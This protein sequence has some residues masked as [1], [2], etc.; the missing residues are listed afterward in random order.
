MRRQP[1][2]FALV[3]AAFLAD[4]K[5]RKLRLRLPDPQAFNSAV[6]AWLVI[7]TAAR[8]NGLP[9]LDCAEEAED[10]TYL[11]DLGASNQTYTSERNSACR[12][13]S[14]RSCDTRRPTNYIYGNSV[15]TKAAKFQEDIDFL[16]GL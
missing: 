5:W 10:T 7:L 9:D 11:A 13:Y 3:D 1:V 12:Y 15:M 14:G 4:T 2:A 6:G 16:K 8:R